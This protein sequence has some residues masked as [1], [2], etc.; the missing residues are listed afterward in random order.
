[1]NKMQASGTNTPKSH[2]P[3]REEPQGIAHKKA[4]I[5]RK[6]EGGITISNIA[7][8]APSTHYIERVHKVAETH[9]NGYIISEYAPRMSEDERKKA[10][11]DIALKIFRAINDIETGKADVSLSALERIK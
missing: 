7:I 2:I 10:K 5:N 3:F 6:H 9:I 4:K 11:Q 8:N 1:M